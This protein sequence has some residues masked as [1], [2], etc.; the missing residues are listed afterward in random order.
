MFEVKKNSIVSDIWY[1]IK[2]YQKYEPIVLW[3]S[4]V[5][6][7]L[8]SILPLIS[9]YIPKIAVDLVSNE[10]TVQD[11]IVILGILTVLKMIFNCINGIVGEG[12]YIYYNNQRTVLMAL[13]CLKSMRIKYEDTEAG[14]I[15]KVY[16]KAIS[17]LSMGDWS[18]NNRM[19]R[20][21]ITLVISVL[22][23]LLYSTVISNLN[24][25]ML[26][27]VM[28]LSL[29]YYIIG[30]RHMKDR[31][32]IMEEVAVDDRHMST[33]KAAMGHVKGAKDIR[34]FGMNHWLIQLR[35]TVL[36]Q[37]KA[38]NRKLQNKISGYEKAGFVIA[39]VRDICAYGYLLYQALEGNVSVGEFVLYF[40]AITGFSSFVSQI[41][42]SILELRTAA[43]ETDYIRTYMDLPEVDQVPKEGWCNTRLETPVKIEFKNISF[44]YK[45]AQDDVEDVNSE[46]NT[47]ESVEKGA[48][49]KEA[50]PGGNQVFKNFNLTIQPGEKLALVGINGA[51]KTTLV[52][53]LCGMY[54]PDEG[55]ILFNG[56][57][58]KNFSSTEIFALFSAVFQ[59]QFVLPFT[60]GENVAM[61][62]S[63]NVEEERAWN[64]LEKASLKAV[65]EKNQWTLKTYLGNSLFKNSAN[66]SGGQ[67]QRLLLARALYKDAPIL[68]LDEPTAALDPISESEIYDCYNQYTEGRTSIFISHRL[69]STRFS[70]RIIMLENGKIIESGTHDELM[71]LNGAYANMYQIQSS[72]Y[73]KKGAVSDGT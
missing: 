52:K 17:S 1:Y 57:S 51:G 58:S 25:W 2:H 48:E 34:I 47:S 36:D 62:K 61:D 28:S 64:A 73:E 22:S 45:E 31:Q 14:E 65:V 69:A 55:E 37:M 12:K 60:L 50:V 44:K 9:I 38:T 33:V 5:E 30:N 43:N 29:I 13:I 41:L 15:K 24:I 54:E 70:D 66:L 63:E 35:D 19:V 46:Q 3:Y 20:C 16:Q 59:E 53:L 18:A 40:G 72:Y 68:V 49:Q 27:F 21:T 26:L 6:I 8:S 71:Q 42:D 56:I 11:A 67:Q 32:K 10:A 23:F 4:A 39:A 7:I